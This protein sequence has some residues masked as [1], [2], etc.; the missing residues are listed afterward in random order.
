M[1]DELTAG[2]TAADHLVCAREIA[3]AAHLDLGAEGVD[4]TAL[5]IQFAR[6]VQ[7]LDAAIALGECQAM[8]LGIAA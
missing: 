5:D 6:V 1:F 2:F 7:H 4:L 3:E 8:P